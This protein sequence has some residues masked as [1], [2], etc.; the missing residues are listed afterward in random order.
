MKVYHSSFE[1]AQQESVGLQDEDGAQRPKAAAHDG[2]E[3]HD[4]QTSDAMVGLWDVDAQRLAAWL[5]NT[6]IDTYSC[7]FMI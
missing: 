3:R 1:F 2:S 4:L 5:D 6:S 7:P